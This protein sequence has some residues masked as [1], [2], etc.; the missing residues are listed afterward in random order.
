MEIKAPKI[1]TINI[2]KPVDSVMSKEKYE[3]FKQNI[4]KVRK[5]ENEEDT[6]L[7]FDELL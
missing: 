1:V 7:L 2:F 4:A 6:R 5:D 3:E